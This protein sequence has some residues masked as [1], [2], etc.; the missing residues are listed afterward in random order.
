MTTAQ[1]K[2]AKAFQA[3]AKEPRKPLKEGQHRCPMCFRGV[4]PTPKGKLH[5]HHNE[6]G[7]PCDSKGIRAGYVYQGTGVDS[8]TGTGTVVTPERKE[9]PVS[10]PIVHT[11]T[12]DWDN[13]T[14]G[15]WYGHIV[16]SR[17]DGETDYQYMYSNVLDYA[18][19]PV[20]FLPE[21]CTLL[22][23]ELYLTPKGREHMW[24]YGHRWAFEDQIGNDAQSYQ[25]YDDEMSV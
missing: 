19:N 17:P 14:P 2:R 13:V 16:F 4:K 6:R 21:G 3:P 10:N 24:H 15:A 20:D 7:V 9:T 18:P 8:L 1:R 25:S 22:E 5:P 11:S 12:G 23:K